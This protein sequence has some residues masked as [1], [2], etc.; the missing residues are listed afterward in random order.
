MK[1]DTA[2]IPCRWG[3]G[4]QSCLDLVQAQSQ[5]L[6][7]QRPRPHSLPGGE[8]N[9]AAQGAQGTRSRGG[10]AARRRRNFRISAP[11]TSAVTEHGVAPRARSD[12]GY[13]QGGMSA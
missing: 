7:G 2:P 9:R 10:A 6:I 1:S 13:A 3:D 5:G 11:A 12:W 8:T 4:S